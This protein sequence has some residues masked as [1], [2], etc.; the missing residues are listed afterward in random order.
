MPDIQIIEATLEHV[1]ELGRS[2]NSEDREE[3]EAMGL[4]AHRALWRSWKDSSFRKAALVDGQ[5]VAI[6]GVVGSFMGLRGRLWMVTGKKAREVS[7][8]YS[9][10]LYRAEV[11]KMLEIFPLLENYVDN[12]YERAVKMLEFGG[13]K[14]D[15]PI[16]VGEKLFRRF[17]KEA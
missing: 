8:I 6:W 2:M 13:F 12:D 11:R 15:D 14:F 5:V 7:P 4:K 3:A 9:A 16:A 17:H 10:L 1:Q